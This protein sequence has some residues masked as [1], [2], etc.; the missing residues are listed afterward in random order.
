MRRWPAESVIDADLAHAEVAADAVD[1]AAGGVAQD[2]LQVVEERIVGPP[3]PRVGHRDAQLASHRALG[4]AD[5]RRAAARDGL[6]TLAGRRAAPGHDEPQHARVDVGRHAQL[7]D[8]RGGHGLQPH[9]LPD[10]G[11]RRVPDA[12]R[13]GHLLAARLPELVGRVVD[14]DRQLLLRVGAQ[15]LGDVDAERVVAAAMIGD[16][17]SV[18]EHGAVPVARAH[19]QQQALAGLH[20]RGPRERAPV[21]DVVGV[22]ADAREPR[23][24]RERHENLPR[25]RRRGGRGQRT[26]RPRA[27]LARRVRERVRIDRHAGHDARVDDREGPEPV[28]AL[29]AR[30]RHLGTRILRQHG[31]RPHLRAPS[32][33]Q[34]AGRGLPGSEGRR[35]RDGR[36][37]IRRRRGRRRRGAAAGQRGREDDVCGA[38]HDRGGERRGRRH[39]RRAW[40]KRSG[41]ERGA[42]RRRRD[43][44]RGASAAPTAPA[45]AP[46]T[47]T[48]RPGAGP[49]VAR[50]TSVASR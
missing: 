9:G 32:R 42:V 30:A 13:L 49:V 41:H 27:A 24:R 10:A 18:H 45:V 11:D 23:L 8:A 35:R 20:P 3:Q 44:R 5:D 15:R 46:P 16:L 17:A 40:R 43:G 22:T 48:A 34:R 37:G 36:G 33:H 4:P 38:A 31:V 6:H 29:P 25:E 19:V 50:T 7:L 1:R 2:D 14:G 21:G 28:E 39:A 47:S 12:L 26:G